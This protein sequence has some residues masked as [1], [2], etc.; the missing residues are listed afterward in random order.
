LVALII[1]QYGPPKNMKFY[2]VNIMTV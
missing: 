2:L 1:T